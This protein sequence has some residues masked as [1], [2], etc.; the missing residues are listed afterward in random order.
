MVRFDFPEDFLFGTATSSFQAEGSAYADGKGES[1]WDYTF[2]TKPELFYKGASPDTGSFFYKHYKEDIKE[3]KA[4]GIKSFRLSI[5]WSR[6]LPN[7]VGEVNQKGIDFYNDV[8]NELL[9]NGIEPFVDIYHWDMPQAIMEKGGFK[10]REMIKWFTDYA[11]VLFES[12]GDRVKF[13]STMNEPAVFCFSAYAHGT[14]IP[15]EKVFKNGILAAHIALLCHYSVIKL[16]RSMNLKGKIGMVTD[17]IP[18]YTA[19]TKD[20]DKRAARRAMD[21]SCDWFLRPVFEGKYPDTILEDCEEYSDNMPENYEKEL[22]DAFEKVDFIGTNYYFPFTAAY[23]AT[24]QTKATIVETYFAQDGQKFAYYPAGL[25]DVME[26]IS[27][28]YGNPPIYITEN[29][30]GKLDSENF[31][32]DTNDNDRVVYLKEHLRMISRCIHAGI[33]IRGYYYWSHF[34]SMESLSGYKYRFGLVYINRETEERTKKKS[35]Y[36]Y[37]DIIKNNMVD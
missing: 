1:I 31:E 4:L 34:D 13:W 7:G 18:V 29:G 5:A 33:N 36:Y 12:F 35:W 32:L 15:F 10:N 2:R 30:L 28:R 17:V 22:S 6:I 8:I 26:Y 24:T 25:Y 20:E 21:T 23:D 3:M 9:K 14:Q 37:Q 27:K 19:S 16:Y 11:R